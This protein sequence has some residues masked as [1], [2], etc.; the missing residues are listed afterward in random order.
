MVPISEEWHHEQP[1]LAAR[2]TDLFLVP[3]VWD[4]TTINPCGKT[5]VVVGIPGFVYRHISTIYMYASMYVCLFGI[6]MHMMLCSYVISTPISTIR[7]RWLLSSLRHA[8]APG[9]T[10]LPHGMDRSRASV[11]HLSANAALLNGFFHLRWL[12]RAVT[13]CPVRNG[14]CKG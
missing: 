2:W 5:V 6:W 11:R 7:F 8:D 9:S 1:Q 14:H 3:G 13:L 4:S 10:Q 12:W